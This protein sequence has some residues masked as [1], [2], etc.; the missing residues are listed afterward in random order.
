MTGRYTIRYRGSTTGG[1]LALIVEDEHGAAYLFTEGTLQLRIRGDGACDQLAGLLGGS[2]RWD[3]V[4][5]VAPYSLAGLDAL[6]GYGRAGS[7]QAVPAR[8]A[9]IAPPVSAGAAGGGLRPRRGG[10]TVVGRGDPPR[11]GHGD[12]ARHGSPA[13]SK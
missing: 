4:P 5:R 6:T 11:R 2:A 8:E 1:A 12:R 3:A 9:G 7:G 13:V 10:A